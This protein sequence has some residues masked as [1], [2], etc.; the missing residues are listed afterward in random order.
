MVNADGSVSISPGCTGSI[1][2]SID[3]SDHAAYSLSNKRSDGSVVVFEV[4]R[5]THNKI[6]DDLVPQ[7]GNS[8]AG[9]KLTDTNTPGT[10]IELNRAYSELMVSGSSNGRVLT[11]SEFF[12][13]FGRN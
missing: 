10:S 5:V 8:G 3:N 4:D 11:Q 1:C 13:E 9:V 12:N 2:V 6:M 7:Q